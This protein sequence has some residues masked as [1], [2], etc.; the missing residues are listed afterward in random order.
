MSERAKMRR[1]ISA[2]DFAKRRELI[3]EYELRCGPYVVTRRDVPNGNR[4][5]WVDSPWPWEYEMED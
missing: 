5:T 3:A 2:Y 1:C 4:W